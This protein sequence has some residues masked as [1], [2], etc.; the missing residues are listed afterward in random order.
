[1][2]YRDIVLADS[3]TNFWEFAETT[4]TTLTATTGAATMSVVGSVNLNQPG[5]AGTKAV[6][7]AGG[8]LTNAYA[9]LLA[10]TNA[11]I[12]FWFKVPVAGAAGTNEYPTFMRR[13]GGGI[14]QLVRYRESTLASPKKFET[15]MNGRSRYSNADINDNK[16]H[17]YVLTK[18]GTT[19]TEYLD[20]NSTTWWGTTSGTVSAGATG[21]TNPFYFLADNAASEI[22][23]DLSI[24]GLAMYNTVALS[25]AR[26]TAHL[27][28]G[29]AAAYTAQTMTATA[30]AGN[31]TVVAESPIIPGGYTA[32]IATATAEMS[33]DNVVKERVTITPTIF[34]AWKDGVKQSIVTTMPI[35][36][37]ADASVNT[38]AI[39]TT[40]AYEVEPYKA[41][42]VMSTNGGN[43]GTYDLYV[44]R[45][46]SN[47]PG[48]AGI[49]TIVDTVFAAT[50]DIKNGKRV[51]LPIPTEWFVGNSTVDIY[52][53]YTGLFY[54]NYN[55][56][57]ATTGKPVLEV[58]KNVLSVPVTVNAQL[59]TASALSI[60][61]SVITEK[62]ISVS[63]Q[64]MTATA[65][66]MN[67]IAS[68]ESIPD[69][70]V[71]AP[72]ATASAVA[73]TPLV[74]AG[75]ELIVAAQ[76]MT[77]TALMNEAGFSDNTEINILAK[78]APA[79]AKLN[80]PKV[81]GFDVGYYD[82]PYYVLTQSKTDGDDLWYRFMEETGTLTV[83]D[84]K[85]LNAAQQKDGA[86]FG[87]PTIGAGYGTH[88]A[89]AFDGLDDYIIVPDSANTPVLDQGS[90]EFYIKTDVKSQVVMTGQGYKQLGNGGSGIIGNFDSPYISTVDLVGG[91]VHI[92]NTRISGATVIP[93]VDVLGNKDVA[94]GNWHQVVIT[95]WWYR[96]DDG[97]ASTVG[98]NLLTRDYEDAGL[99]ANGIS[100]YVDGKLDRRIAFQNKKEWI[101]IAQPDT[102]GLVNSRFFRGE[103]SEIVH[104]AFYSLPKYFIEQAY[105][106]FFGFNPIR[107]EVLAAKAS[108]GDTKARGNTKK[109]LTLFFRFGGLTENAS[110]RK[111]LDTTWTTDKRLNPVFGNIG[112]PQVNSSTSI[113]DSFELFPGAKMYF[114]SALQRGN[115]AGVDGYF[116]DS[117]TDEPRYIN[118]QTDIDV[119]DFDAIM[120]ANLPG[121]EFDGSMIPPRNRGQKYDDFLESLKIAVFDQGV[122]LMITMPHLAEQLGLVDDWDSKL[123][124]WDGPPV[125]TTAAPAMYGKDYR[126]AYNNPFRNSEALAGRESAYRNEIALSDDRFRP[127]PRDVN[128]SMQWYY[129]THRNSNHRVAA[130][131]PGFTDIPGFTLD[132]ETL[133]R[134]APRD[135]Q[136]DLMY[137]AKY[138][139]HETGLRVGDEFKIDGP[140]S[141]NYEGHIAYPD[142]RSFNLISFKPEDINVGTAI[143]K[144]SLYLD[145][146]TQRILNPSRENA[147]VIVV[148]P[149]MELDGRVINGKIVIMSN[150][151][152]AYDTIAYFQ[153]L[154]DTSWPNTFN[155]FETAESE[156]WT[157]SMERIKTFEITINLTSYEVVTGRNGATAIKSTNRSQKLT[158]YANVVTYPARVV[159]MQERAWNW[160]IEPADIVDDGDVKFRALAATANGVMNNPNVGTV[161]NA[162]VNTTVANATAQM[163]RVAEDGGGDNNIVILPMTAT[164]QFIQ[165]AKKIYVEAATASA[166]MI[167]PFD[168]I[169]DFEDVV[170]MTLNRG[171][172]ITLTRNGETE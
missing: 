158:D 144:E 115:G 25:A 109:I 170:Y 148:E 130:L 52:V 30:A 28:A 112:A 96:E 134:Y 171:S 137:S 93:G 128:S 74:I 87:N 122:D 60:N 118:L 40:G 71:S 88:R 105:Y 113:S 138:G 82:D 79:N 133:Y 1:M 50:V 165:P 85:Y 14:T 68:G 55:S 27:T 8:Y 64:T 2:A 142:P 15:Y 124:D 135:Y 147:T 119:T 153:D 51:E 163:M 121:P 76:L 151:N 48:N 39:R 24:S 95:N 11:T 16:W 139:Q 75:N 97:A 44:S 22:A 98:N 155:E 18:A 72:V 34:A 4:G 129:D 167:D 46:T 157:V 20:G 5:P 19:W 43:S 63:A 56:P 123:V 61:P 100:I 35:G 84:E 141:G 23:G 108:A 65:E 99:Q 13:D 103:L 9:D 69:V 17:H 7:S 140:I 57:V 159:T 53:S 49:P 32:Q 38:V 136:Q 166:E 42:L 62:A 162:R 45:I 54:R 169:F 117:V 145:N 149:G 107:P 86:V 89:M 111:G 156:K 160:L 59:M 132:E 81:N 73:N 10:N 3:P 168:S 161:R 146:G 37:G 127:N 33:Q 125:A 83:K 152:M 150:D 77:A 91:R 164:A 58:F 31:A 47:F 12:E 21:T 172:L 70:T 6:T 29:N 110:Y 101:Y 80:S 116:R 92:A 36:R 66:S 106:A 126:A 154:S 94:D 26:V 102:I 41:R 104:R 131:L 67:A 114:Q 78:V 90:L 120:F 143:A